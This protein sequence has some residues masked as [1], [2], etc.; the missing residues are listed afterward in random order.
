MN[1]LIVLPNNV[2]LLPN[3]VLPNN[4]PLLPNKVLPNNVPLLPNK[5]LPNNVPLLPNK[6]LAKII[7]INKKW[8]KTDFKQKLIY[9]FII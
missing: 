9:F 3:K 1:I 5:V 4:V 8:K 6:V 2:P 7:F